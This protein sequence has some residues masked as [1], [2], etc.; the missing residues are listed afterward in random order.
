[1]W[2]P[3]HGGRRQATAP[4]PPPY[5]S[6]HSPQRGLE[7]SKVRHLQLTVSQATHVARTLIPIVTHTLSLP[8]QRPVQRAQNPPPIRSLVQ[9]AELGRRSKAQSRSEPCPFCHRPN[10]KFTSQSSRIRQILQVDTREALNTRHE[11]LRIGGPTN[12]KPRDTHTYTLYT[13]WPTL[14]NYS[15][16]RRS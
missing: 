16:S 4:P 6:K 2:S 10:S 12:L 13:Q 7:A 9:I 11:K 14:P 15:S 1:M 5:R 3:R 8:S